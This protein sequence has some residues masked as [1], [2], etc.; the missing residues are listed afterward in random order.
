MGTKIYQLFEYVYLFM[1]AFSIYLV[2]SNWQIDRNRA[3][4]FVIFTVVA[5]F[6]FF[7]KRNF[8]KKIEQ[9]NNNN[10]T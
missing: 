7:F 9:N 1:A 4:L 10:K 5:I 8:R 6:M 2:I 3:Y